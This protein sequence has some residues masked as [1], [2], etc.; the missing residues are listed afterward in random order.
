LYIGRFDPFHLGH[1][2]AYQLL[3][4]LVDEIKIGIGAQR[5]EDYFTL[6]ERKKMVIQN[7]GIKPIYLEDLE[8]DHPFYLDWGKYVLEIVGNMDIVAT[9]NEYVREDFSNHN[10]PALWLPRYEGISGT[11][12][13]RKI[14]LGDDSWMGLVPEKTIEIIVSSEKF[15]RNIK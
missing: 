5:K 13:R 1:L 3:E 4:S 10:I 6:N 12:I 8:E 2:K 7:T 14:Q 15:R 11:E 9:G